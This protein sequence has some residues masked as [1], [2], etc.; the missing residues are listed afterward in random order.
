MPRVLRAPTTSENTKRARG[1]LG[2]YFSTMHC[3]VCH[4]LTVEGVCAKCKTQPQKVAVT[5]SV[6][7]KNRERVYSEMANVSL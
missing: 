7:I 6:K 4:Q 5:L 3:P 1:T 2:Q